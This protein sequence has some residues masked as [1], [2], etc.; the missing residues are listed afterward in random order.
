MT[1]DDP[2]LSTCTPCTYCALSAGCKLPVLEHTLPPAASTHHC[3]VFGEA[4]V[5]AHAT[6]ALPS[7]PTATTGDSAAPGLAI[8]EGAATA[9]AA[10]I[11]ITTAATAATTHFRRIQPPIRSPLG[12]T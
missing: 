1:M 11:S 10:Q 4:I 8:M 9:Q 6:I 3:T 2:S 7:E 12:P 5:L